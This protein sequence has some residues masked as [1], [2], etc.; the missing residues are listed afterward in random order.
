MAAERERLRRVLNRFKKDE[1]PSAVRW[2]GR[3][4]EVSKRRSKKDIISSTL[5]DFV[6]SSGL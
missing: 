3:R 1:L 5:D 4:E 6:V 2:I